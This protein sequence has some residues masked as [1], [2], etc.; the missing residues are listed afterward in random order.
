[1]QPKLLSSGD[2]EDT[3]AD[4]RSWPAYLRAALK[5]ITGAGLVVI[6]FFRCYSFWKTDFNETMGASIN[7]LG[8]IY[9]YGK[10][11]KPVPARTLNPDNAFLTCLYWIPLGAGSLLMIMAQRLPKEGK[12]SW[13][14]RTQLW[15]G[16]RAGQ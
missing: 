4:V 11:V 6:I 15:V 5:L 7:K 2:C 3:R 1:M 13:L 12:P 8:T 14:R 10:N 9:T 16:T